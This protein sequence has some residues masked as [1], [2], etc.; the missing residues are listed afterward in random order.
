[1]GC[2]F[3]VNHSPSFHTDTEIDCDIKESLLKDTFVILNLT[4]ADKKKVLDEDR[5]RV[6][7]R[8]L[9]GTNCKM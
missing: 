7:E 3:Q 9:Q 5:R 8:L 1:M 6:C 2:L 4:Q